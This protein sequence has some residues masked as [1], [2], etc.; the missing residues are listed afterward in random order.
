[1]GKGLPGWAWVVESGLPGWALVVGN[2]GQWVVPAILRGE[3]AVDGFERRSQFF[4]G[5]KLLLDFNV[6]I[7]YK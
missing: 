3:P 6:V 5:G 2:D 1:M 7:T 4:F